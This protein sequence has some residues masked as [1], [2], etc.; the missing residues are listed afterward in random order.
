MLKNSTKTRP[1]LVPQYLN[2]FSCIGSECEDSCC[3]GWKVEIDQDT[4]KKY[5]KVQDK[6]LKPLLEKN[7]KKNRSNPTKESYA[8]IKMGDKGRCS[9]LSEANLCQIQL[10][11]GTDYLSNTC[12]IY[13]RILNKVNGIVEKSLTMSCPEA[14]RLALLNPNGIEF[15]Q[16]EEPADSAG[17]IINQIDTQDEKFTNKAQR[18]FWEFRIFTIQVLQNR[19]YSLSERL[20]ILGLFFKNAQEIIEEGEI[21]NILDLIIKYSNH[22]ENGGLKSIIENIPTQLSIQLKLCKE[23]IDVRY[24]QGISNQRYLECISEMLKGINY[25]NDSTVEEITERYKLAY[26]EYYLPYM[27]KHEYILENYLVNHVFKNLFPLKKQSLFDDYVMLVIYYSMIKLHLIGMAGFHKGITSDMVLK[28][29][30]SFSKTVDHNDSFLRN[31][32]KLLKNNGLNSMAYM[33]ILI[34]N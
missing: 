32:F 5:Q 31:I 4:Y 10:K 11:L 26:E 15:D 14:A 18:Y 1:L 23:L 21:H 33:A 12:A 22:M 25:D 7:V 24:G 34:K 29:I 27:E 6:E 13:P 30:Q 17:F 8:K 16:I 2:K 19:S 28:L 20:I 3:I 9:Y